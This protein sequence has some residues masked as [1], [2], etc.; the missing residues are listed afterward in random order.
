MKYIASELDRSNPK[1]LGRSEIAIPSEPPVTSRHFSAT[2]NR[3][4]EKASVSSEK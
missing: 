1:K 4:C 2:E 3:S